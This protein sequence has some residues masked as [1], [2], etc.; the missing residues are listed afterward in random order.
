KSTQKI[1]RAMQMVAA[2]K[3]RR[4]QEAVE[5]SRPYSE[6]MEN[7]LISVSANIQSSD[8]Q[9]NLLTGNGRKD[10][11][12]LV[13]ATSER[14]LCGGFNS[15][16]VRK[17]RVDIDLLTKEG[18]TIKILCIGKKGR[19]ILRR[20]FS[21]LILDTIDLGD[22]KNISYTDVVPISKKIIEYFNNNEFDICNFY[23]NKFV[24]VIVQDVQ[25]NQLIP[26]S[27]NISKDD[28]SNDLN[29]TSQIGD[30]VYEF[31]PE[32]D[33]ILEFLLPKNLSVQLFQGLLENSASE[34]GAR[35]TAMDNA[36]R[37]AGEMID[38]LTLSY[39]RTR[40][41]VITSELIEIISGAEAL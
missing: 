14:G 17:V 22:V 8:G 6:R 18:K 26:A 35:M 11:Y 30:A 36:T 9:A 25:T 12:L 1:T 4:A 5:S 23:F 32:E 15:S 27:L 19:D 34:Q 33:E 28:S 16:I 2:S 29:S 41:A 37:N 38:E 13:V 10:T 39:N 21:D 3:L 24:S 7:V 40:Q 20:D 31:E